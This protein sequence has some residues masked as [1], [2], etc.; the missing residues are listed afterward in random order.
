MV[1]QPAVYLLGGM[2]RVGAVA[3]L[4]MIDR[5]KETG[6]NDGSQRGIGVAKNENAIGT[7]LL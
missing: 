7:L 4:H 5:D 1:D 3:R 2:R 6:S